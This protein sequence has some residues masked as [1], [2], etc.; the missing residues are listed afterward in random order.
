MD[1]KEIRKMITEKKA[2]MSQEEIEEFSGW[3]TERFCSLEEFQSAPCL[4]AYNSFNQEVR[5]DGIIRK[6]LEEGK[7]VAVP[8]VIGTRME[9]RYISS[10]DDLEPGLM[11]IPEPKDGLEAA[12]GKEPKILMLTP[13]LAFDPS[14]SRIGYG[15]GLYDRYIGEHW[16]ENITMI[17]LCYDFQLLD[18]IE[19]EPFD[20]KVDL[21]I[22]ARPQTDR[23]KSGKS[24]RA[25]I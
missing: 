9:F 2:R 21:V 15:K 3:L 6:A 13:G 5:T 4:F 19:T 14:G 22:A 25:L 1:K 7:R 20:R 10:P 23:R 12:D 24:D 11:G 17:A 18:Y 16:R 8:K